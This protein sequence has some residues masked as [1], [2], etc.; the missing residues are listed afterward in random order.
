MTRKGATG[1]KEE[2]RGSS[3]A[4]LAP[5]ETAGHDDS[6]TSTRSPSELRKCR[7]CGQEMETSEFR[8]DKRAKNGRSYPRH[9]CR[10]C[11]NKAW[12]R[13]WLAGK[14]GR[15]SGAVLVVNTPPT[16]SPSA[17]QNSVDGHLEEAV[18]RR[19]IHYQSDALDALHALA[20]MPIS[21]NSMQNQVKLAAASKLAVALLAPNPTGGADADLQ[22]F[23]RDLDK[24][25]RA[26]APR[27]KSIRER[28]IAFEHDPS[29]TPEAQRIGGALPSD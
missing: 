8:A 19:M 10:A 7:K 23:L 29:G 6:D 5:D 20:M 21:E 13:D 4:A 2:L 11:E 18:S 28:I 22:V 26:T 27:I 15:Q 24:Q 25:Y 1:K 12:R 14:K 16:V 17:I 9:Q 3:L